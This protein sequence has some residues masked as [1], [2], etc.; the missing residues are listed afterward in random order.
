[1]KSFMQVWHQNAHERADRIACQHVCIIV[2]AGTD[3]T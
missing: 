3:T 2:L 1:M